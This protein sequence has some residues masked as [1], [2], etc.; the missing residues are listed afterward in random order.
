MIV[1]KHRAKTLDLLKDEQCHTL[2]G[3]TTNMHTHGYKC[4]IKSKHAGGLHFQIQN[5]KKLLNLLVCNPPLKLNRTQDANN[6][7]SQYEMT[8]AKTLDLVNNRAL[9]YSEQQNY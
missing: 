1:P 6:S 3:K 2:N 9:S 8:E 5:H 7:Q 4:K